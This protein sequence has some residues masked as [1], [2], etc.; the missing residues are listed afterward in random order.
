MDKNRI[1][2]QVKHAIKK[3]Q[4]VDEDLDF[5]AESIEMP[6]DIKAFLCDLD[7]KIEQVA[8]IRKEEPFAR[9]YIYGLKKYASWMEHSIKQNDSKTAQRYYLI[10]CKNLER[11]KHDEWVS[12]VEKQFGK[13]ADNKRD[14]EQDRIS[15]RN[16]EMQKVADDIFSR[17]PDLS[18][19][20][21][22]ELIHAMAKK[23]EIDLGGIG[24]Q[25]IRKVIH[26]PKIK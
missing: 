4:I 23:G 8:I 2:R 26:K 7:K 5:Q 12:G 9:E 14:A 6:N 24:E 22:A 25:T 20:A 16:K 10:I 11:L 13:A 19:K 21:V 3:A 1:E 15:K 18:K 17:K